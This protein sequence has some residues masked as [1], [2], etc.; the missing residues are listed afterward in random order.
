MIRLKVI[1]VDSHC[2]C[3]PKQAA[4]RVGPVEDIIAQIGYENIKHIRV[5]ASNGSVAYH[6]I[7]Y[8]DNQPYTPRPTSQKKG[9]FG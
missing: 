7:F 5:Q 8:E 1:A 4:D 9:L 3:D 2:A 6:N